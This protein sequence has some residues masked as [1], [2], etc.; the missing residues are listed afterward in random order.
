MNYRLAL[1]KGSRIHPTFHV[2]LL[3]KA[4][5]GTKLQTTLDVHGEKE[6]K[7]EKILDHRQISR[8]TQ[9]LVKWK[10]YDTMENTWEPIQNLNHCEKLWLEYH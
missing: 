3:E 7:V 1:P 8:K 5:P 9:Y 6:Y 10:D 2:S 4:L